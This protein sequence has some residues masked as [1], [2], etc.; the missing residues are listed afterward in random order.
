[1]HRAVLRGTEAAINR[2]REQ[3]LTAEEQSSSV[4]G[5]ALIAQKQKCAEAC[6]ECW[7]GSL[8]EMALIRWPT[9]PSA[10]REHK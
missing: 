6:Q 7:A 2:Q 10:A 9:S 4:P 1:M 5:A 3:E 8:G